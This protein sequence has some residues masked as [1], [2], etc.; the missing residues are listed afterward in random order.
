MGRLER[1]AAGDRDRPRHTPV[2]EGFRSRDLDRRQATSVQSEARGL[3]IGS[4]RQ[5]SG[6][7]GV[8]GK[9]GEDGIEEKARITRTAVGVFHTR[10]GRWLDTEGREMF[11]A[12]AVKIS[13]TSGQE[14]TGLLAEGVVSRP[15]DERRVG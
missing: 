11:L 13:N 15:V 12:L 5:R 7:S 1:R 8:S 6:R 10:R 4:R 2:R 14:A 3:R 9:K